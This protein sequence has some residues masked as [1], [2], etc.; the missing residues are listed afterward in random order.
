MPTARHGVG[1]AATAGFLIYVADAS[2]YVGSVALLL[3][4]NFGQPA[5]SWLDFFTAFSYATAAFC[6]VCF[7]LSAAYFFRLSR[8]AA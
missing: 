2:G 5:L 4:K 1:R 7:A 3:Y 8:R 6:T